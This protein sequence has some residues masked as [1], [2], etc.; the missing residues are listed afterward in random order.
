MLPLPR[1]GVSSLVKELRLYMPQ[2]TA[3]K[4]P[5]HN[6]LKRRSLPKYKG[7]SIASKSA[8]R[9]VMYMINMLLTLLY[10]IYESC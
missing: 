5:K 1:A 10:V 8:M 9:D 2:N 3:Q 6:T 7:I 4:K